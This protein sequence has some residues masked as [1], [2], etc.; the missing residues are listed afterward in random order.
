MKGQT[1][2]NER[3][4]QTEERNN[5]LQAL[6]AQGRVETGQLEKKI[7]TTKRSS[8]NFIKKKNEMI[9][10]TYLGA[11]YDSQPSKSSM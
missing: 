11:F 1:D 4:W 6:L 7:M 8:W 3:G 2:Q 5:R 9:E 10:A